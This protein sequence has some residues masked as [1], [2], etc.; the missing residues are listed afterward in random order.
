MIAAMFASE[1][2]V[3]RINNEF[4]ARFHELLKKNINDERQNEWFKKL[5]RAMLQADDHFAKKR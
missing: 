1:E 2:N 3:N 5:L 4:Y